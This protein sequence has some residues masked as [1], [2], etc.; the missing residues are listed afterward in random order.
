M[1]FLIKG[2]AHMASDLFSIGMVLY[3]LYNGGES[4]LRCR[5]SYGQYRSSVDEVSVPIFDGE[6]LSIFVP[7]KFVILHIRFIFG[8]SGQLKSVKPNKLLNLPESLR[9]YIKMLVNPD[10]NVRP[11]AHELLKVCTSIHHLF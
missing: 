6:I 7:N 1:F 11:D 2:T 3:A 4:L 10:V 9:D 5:D 8:F